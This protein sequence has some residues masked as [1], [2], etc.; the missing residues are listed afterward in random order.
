V[1]AT[2]SNIVN[3]IKVN[4][5][6]QQI[7]VRRGQ[8]QVK[9]VDVNG[10]FNMINT[11]S[12]DVPGITNITQGVGVSQR[13]GDT[14]FYKELFINYNITMANADNFNVSRVI[15]FQWHPNTTLVI[16][17]PADILQSVTVYSMYDWQLSNQYKILYDKVHFMTGAANAPTTG[18]SQGYFGSIDLSRVVRRAEFSPGVVGGSEQLFILLISDSAVIPFPLFNVITRLTYSEE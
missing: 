5:N 16:P 6:G 1:M 9:F 4:S 12:I 15:I 17:V 13:T 7:A 3:S 2:N 18:S 11:G 10:S 14:I 8:P